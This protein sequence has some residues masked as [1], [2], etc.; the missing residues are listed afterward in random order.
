MKK[1]QSNTEKQLREAIRSIIRKIVL[2]EGEEQ[3]ASPD[4]KAP[5]V[6]KAAMEIELA[7]ANFLRKL[8]SVATTMPIESLAEVLAQITEKYT[9]SSEERLN[10]LKAVRDRIIK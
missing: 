2:K 10:T 4:K 9:V 3:P 7:T 5:E 8:S 1:I 6:D